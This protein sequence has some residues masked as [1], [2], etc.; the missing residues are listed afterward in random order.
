MK[1][2]ALEFS[3]A[4]RSVAVVGQASCLSREAEA[5]AMLKQL[6]KVS[7]PPDR[8]DACPTICE[9]IETSSGRTM[10]PFQMIESTL[11]QAGLDRAQIECI[12]VGLGPGSYNGIRAGIAVAQGWQLA[13][14]VKL[15]GV[16]SAEAIA[17]QAQ[18]D[19]L[20]GTVLVTM[21]AQRGEWYL[22]VWELTE[23]G[24]RETEPLR[25]VSAEAVLQRVA[26]GS[27]LIGPEATQLTSG[28][29]LVFPRAAMLAELARHRTT[30]VSGES[31]EPIY[32]RETSFVKAPPARMV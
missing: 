32:L 14:N 2:L 30:F 24:H 13:S 31:L 7:T 28:A 1:I 19:G 29:K 21:D 17:A 23:N 18:A 11:A 20:R 15:L 4:Q 25:I 10:Q 22:G 3:S 16:S 5:A 9:A 12:V 26:G 27:I 8:Q 6:P